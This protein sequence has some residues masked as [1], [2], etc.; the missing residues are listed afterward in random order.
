MD[1]EKH[2]LTSSVVNGISPT[3]PQ[4]FYVFAVRRDQFER[5]EGNHRVEDLPAVGLQI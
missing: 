4:A 2:K 5:L 3:D 1:Y